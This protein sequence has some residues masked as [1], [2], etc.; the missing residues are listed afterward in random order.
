[1]K[2]N[3]QN[4]DKVTLEWTEKG[5]CVFN[6]K[7]TVPADVVAACQK[8][9]LRYAIKQANIPGFRQGQA[10]A[11]IV[12]KRYKDTIDNDVREA[13]IGSVFQ[14]AKAD[15]SKKMLSFAIPK[16]EDL[17]FATDKEATFTCEIEVAPQI[18]IPDYK[19]LEVTVHGEEVT[20]AAIQKRKDAIRDAF[21]EF[22]KIEDTLNKHDLAQVSYDADVTLPEDAPGTLKA[23]VHA[24][25]TW[26]WLGENERIPGITD[27]IIG[28]KVGEDFEFDATFPEDTAEPFLSGK[29]LKYKGSVK[30][31]QRRAPLTDD[32]LLLE[33]MGMK[34]IE[35]FNQRIEND[36]KQES[37]DRVHTE[38]LEK[39]SE[40]LAETVPDF[41][42]PPGVIAR[43]TMQH[44]REISQEVIKSEADVPAFQANREAHET[45]AKKRAEKSAH[46]FFILAAIADAEGIKV[47]QQDFH[48]R[49]NM[50]AQHLQQSVEQTM[51]VIQDRD[52]E[53][54]VIDDILGNKTLEA[55]SKIVKIKKSK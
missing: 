8:E 9:T 37:D 40:K 33:R 11:A 19:K 47:S 42:M 44:L 28:K 45:E 26:I 12:A 32:K 25:T 34:T 46:L 50:I 55:L 17:T 10:P 38:V 41:S 5:P 27:A 36:L 43:K 52:I 23:L 31:A 7:A 30:D 14:K 18:T 49:V 15:E 51:K 1:M 53:Q 29:T 13:V 2:N 20:E 21:G 35:D 48:D 4:L 39:I 6:V 24:T 3:A 22:V 54:D 16:E